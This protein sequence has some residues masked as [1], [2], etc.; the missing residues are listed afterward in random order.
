MRDLRPNAAL[1]DIRM[2]PTHTDEG[3]RAA[4][5]VRSDYPATAVLVLSQ[6]LEPDYAL[7]LVETKPEHVGHLMKERVGKLG[8]PTSP[9]GNRRVLAVLTHLRRS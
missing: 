5:E 8:I 4:R 7:R 1:V 9:E 6:H 2:P 3:L